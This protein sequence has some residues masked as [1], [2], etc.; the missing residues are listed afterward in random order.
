[1]PVFIAALLGGLVSAMGSM[2]GRVMV[3]LGLG[4]VTFQGVD[5]LLSGAKALVISNLGTLPPQAYQVASTLKVGVVVS[6][7]TSAYLV[8][9]AFAG[10]SSGVIKKI[11]SK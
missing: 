6:I 8:R 2:V 10:L 3:A 9:L 4:F 7:I 5:A 11:I 1:M